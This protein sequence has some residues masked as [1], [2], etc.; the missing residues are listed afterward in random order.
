M[1]TIEITTKVRNPE[2][3]RL[4]KEAKAKKQEIHKLLAK[5]VHPSDIPADLK[6]SFKK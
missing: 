1:R 3:I 6:V 5:G 2:V 4:I